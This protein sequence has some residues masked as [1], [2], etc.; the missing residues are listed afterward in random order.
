MVACA[1]LHVHL[2]S[3]HKRLQRVHFTLGTVSRLDIVTD[4]LCS[5]SLRGRSVLL[6]VLP[7]TPRRLSRR[8]L[9]RSPNVHRHQ[10]HPHPSHS[11]TRRLSMYLSTTAAPR[12][13]GRFASVNATKQDHLRAAVSQQIEVVSRGVS[14]LLNIIASLSSENVMD[15]KE[16]SH[17]F[18]S[19]HVRGHVDGC[20]QLS[21]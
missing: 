21:D 14:N 16:P 19:S 12:T 3:S 4:R 17:H 7:A 11:A 18:L 1:A 8:E 15:N 20:R 13:P 5:G 6:E 2:Y 9:Q 10:S